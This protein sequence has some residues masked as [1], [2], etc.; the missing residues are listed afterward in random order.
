MGMHSDPNPCL[1]MHVKKKCLPSPEDWLSDRTPL[2]LWAP[3][4]SPSWEKNSKKINFIMSP[5]QAQ[6]VQV[7][8]FKPTD[9]NSKKKCAS[10]YYI[11]IQR[12][13]SLEHYKP[14]LCYCVWVSVL[15]YFRN[16]EHK[17]IVI[18]RSCTNR[19]LIA[20][21]SVADSWQYFPAVRPEKIRPL[22]KKVWLPSNFH[23][24]KAYRLKK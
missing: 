4:V 2:T 22:R 6:L 15:H 14:Y 1:F 16:Y 9:G 21:H 12:D 23:H 17:I 10:K 3:S 19:L 13:N 18:I 24:L 5:S 11:I 8:L 20:R 7:S